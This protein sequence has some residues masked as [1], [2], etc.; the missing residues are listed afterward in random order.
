M[1]AEISEAGRA[2]F[3]TVVTDLSSHSQPHYIS[4]RVIYIENRR[5]IF[6]RVCII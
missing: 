2:R 3:D 1:R 6:D 4:V 5:E